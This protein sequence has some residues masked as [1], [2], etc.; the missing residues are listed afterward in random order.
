MR[1]KIIFCHI[2]KSGGTSLQYLIRNNYNAY[3]TM[4]PG[5]FSLDDHGAKILTAEKFQQFRKFQPFCTG[6]GGHRVNYMKITFRMNQ[7]LN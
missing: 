5:L 4:N 1:K 7:L 3:V 6:L 2:E